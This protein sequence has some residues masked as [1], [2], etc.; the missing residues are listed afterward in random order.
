[1]PAT[2]INEQA[3][4][5]AESGVDR[6]APDVISKIQ[7]AIT[8]ERA[9]R[10]NFAAVY[11][12]AT[13]RGLC[14]TFDDESVSLGSGV[15]SEVWPLHALPSVDEIHW[16]SLSDVPIALVT[17]ANGKTTTTRLVAAMW[18]TTRRTAGWCCSDGV[19]VD[20]DQLEAGDYSGPSGARE[21]LRDIRVEAAVLETARGGMLRRGLAVQRADA[22]I[23]TNISA[24][25]FGEYGIEN[26]RDLAG[27]KAIVARVLGEDGCLVLNADDPALLELAEQLPNRLAWFSASP[28][29]PT[30]DDHVLHGGDAATLHEGRVLLH[31]G[32]VWHDLD[33]VAGMP[34]TLGGTAPHNVV[35]VLGAALLG[36]ALGVSVEAVRGTL[37]TFGASEKDN[38][39]RLHIYRLGGV[40]VLVDFAHNPGGIAALCE[41]AMAMPARRRLLVLG[42]AGN[43]DDDQLR[44]L[45]RAA[46]SVSAFDRVIIKELPTKLGARTL[47]ELPQIFVQELLRLGL[48]REQMEVGTGEMDAMRRALSWAA[49]GDLL[50][51]P[52]HVEK[53]AVLAWLRELADTGWTAGVPL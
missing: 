43:R 19:W 9:S 34:I 4:V 44:A 24:D 36:V 25:H 23:I 6:I 20:D 40:T 10:P 41:T 2:E 31:C 8:F 47:D 38:P 50:V 18:R 16:H 30:L 12:E 39:G 28:A 22:A 33:D 48:A 45:V 32:G 11:D 35:N 17:G 1:M 13:S 26:I 53:A 46:W 15:G 27:V 5:A 14:V 21:V 52:I 37:V 29:H 42:Q 51:C 7:A 3:W 49:D